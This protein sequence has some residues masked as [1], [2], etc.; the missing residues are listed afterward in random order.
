MIRPELLA[1][2]NVFPTP[3]QM[4]AFFTVGPV[5]QAAQRLRTRMW[6]RFKAGH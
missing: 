3:A 6:A 2:T 4:T 5:P 1:D